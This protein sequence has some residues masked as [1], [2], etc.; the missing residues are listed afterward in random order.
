MTKQYTL[1]K[2]ASVNHKNTKL[3]S[4]STSRS[5]NLQKYRKNKTVKKA[6]GA[7]RLKL[8]NLRGGVKWPSWWRWGR[9][10]EIAPPLP[11]RRMTAWANTENV[12]EKS[13]VLTLTTGHEPN[14]GSEHKTGVLNKHGAMTKQKIKER[15]AAKAAKA[16]KA[17][18]AAAAAAA[19]EA[20]AI[21]QRLT[22]LKTHNDALKKTPNIIAFTHL[23]YKVWPDHGA[24]T[25]KNYH[26][27]RIY[28]LECYYAITKHS[29]YD[30]TVIHC[31]AGVGRSGTIY[32]LLQCMFKYGV[33]CIYEKM[34]NESHTDAI[35]IDTIIDMI[36]E[37]RKYRVS[38]VQSKEQFMFIL[39]MLGLRSTSSTLTK[40]EQEAQ[41]EADNKKYNA[42][43][44]IVDTYTQ[45]EGKEN[46]GKNRYKNI[47]PYDYNI[48]NN[49][50]KFYINASVMEPFYLNSMRADAFNVILAQG[51]NDSTL[52]EFYRM[53]DCYNVKTIIMLT[54]LIEGSTNKCA[55]YI[56]LNSTGID[57][58]IMSDK[59]HSDNY[60]ICELK[61]TKDSTNKN[62]FTLVYEPQPINACRTDKS[63]FT[64]DYIKDNLKET[65]VMQ[66]VNPIKWFDNNPLNESSSSDNPNNPNNPNF[67]SVVM[68]AKRIPQEIFFSSDEFNTRF[69]T[70][71]WF[72]Q[73]TYCNIKLT[74]YPNIFLCFCRDVVSQQGK[75]GTNTYTFYILIPSIMKPRESVQTYNITFD[76]VSGYDINESSITM[77]FDRA[78]AYVCNIKKESIKNDK[79]KSY[80]I[81]PDT[82]CI[83]PIQDKDIKS[84]E[85]IDKLMNWSTDGTDITVN[86]V[87]LKMF[88]YANNQII[89]KDT[90]KEENEV[91]E[92][93]SKILNIDG[94][95]VR[96]VSTS[97]DKTTNSTNAQVSIAKIEANFIYYSTTKIFKRGATCK[98]YNINNNNKAKPK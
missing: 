24:P 85:S 62:N 26:I 27:F 40:K 8:T 70:R 68:D 90:T 36:T 64:L 63:N 73:R 56:S 5:Y 79:D 20:A 59:S 51:P 13:N 93:V 6:N 9:K 16:A 34:P 66:P 88:D 48:A 67:E 53:L 98:T 25:P 28:L 89:Y 50:E 35:T 77:L 15:N 55:A 39:M 44:Q 76:F 57:S 33:E 29:T 7:N 31:S 32:I 94:S 1:K 72:P 11:P 95:I 18:A 75:K 83:L 52:Q 14:T 91:N 22:K 86:S 10:R 43:K 84:I 96:T 41:T 12:Q 92:L 37:A 45:T 54:N 49:N 71:G 61:L 82:M 4:S 30:T 58:K 2:K 74:K 19:A 21:E 17:A 97:N 23:W 87:T 60:E 46:A 80:E 78:D 81:P 3:R 42:I 47:I 65:P 38:I 69:G